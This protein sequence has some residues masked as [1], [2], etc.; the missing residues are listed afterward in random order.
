MTVQVY[1]KQIVKT[2]GV[3]PAFDRLI[4][5]GIDRSCRDAAGFTAAAY[6]AVRR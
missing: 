5:V 6:V 1:M 4:N 3:R 2:S